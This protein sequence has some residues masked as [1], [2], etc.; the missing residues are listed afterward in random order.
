MTDDLLR[1]RKLY[2][3][4]G[5]LMSL[6]MGLVY[7]WSIFVLPLEKQ[8]GWTRA[9]TQ[10]TFTLAIMSFCVGMI[11][12]G[13]LADRF[14]PRIVASVGAIL[15]TI[16]F[17]LASYTESLG[18]L[19][20]SY[21]ILVGLGIGIADIVVL[22]AAARWYPDKRGLAIGAMAMGFGL[23][24]FFFGG[25][26][27][28]FI[29]SL[30]WQWA[31]RTLALAS[32]VVLVGGGLLMLYPPT[33]W[34]PPLPGGST[35]GVAPAP[36]RNFEWYEMFRTAP[37]WL[38]WVWDLVLCIAGMMVLAHVVP[39]AVEKG[40][41]KARAAW[42]MGLFA[43]F[44][45][46]GRLLFGWLYDQLGRNKTMVLSAAVMAFGV[47]GI[48]YLTQF[49]GFPGL[50]V[51]IMCTGLAYGGL[52]VINSTFIVGSYG[53]KNAG[54]H[55]GLATTPLMVAVFIGPYLGSFVQMSFGYDLTIVLGGL[56]AVLGVIVA[57]FIGDAQKLYQKS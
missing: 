57:F 12:G 36:L 26:M 10:L 27:G 40:L 4:I 31:F 55:I 22:S 51:S 50:F 19:Y 53:P 41:D 11:F 33:G 14:G 5:F 49:M 44:N 30:G 35:G 48:R 23:A 43:L 2:L 47:F 46:L 28:Q 38:W 52:P 13:R 3:I 54:L 32:L 15:S 20:F 17:F 37:W 6:V 7:A 39:L 1:K 45:G 42:A 24:G 25:L 8:F 21:G 16:G 56:V 34:A 18:M 29:G 9:Q